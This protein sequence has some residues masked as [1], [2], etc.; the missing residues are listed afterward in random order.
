M[1]FDKLIDRY[2]ELKDELINFTECEHD[3]MFYDIEG[4]LSESPEEYLQELKN[5]VEAFEMIL[6]GFKKVSYIF[7]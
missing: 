5:Q 2:I 4:Y 7:S 6:K 1:N 3:N